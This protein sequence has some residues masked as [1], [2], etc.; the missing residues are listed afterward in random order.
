[1]KCTLFHTDEKIKKIRT[2]EFPLVFFVYD[3]V[4]DKGS[5]LFKKKKYREAIEYYIYAYSMLKWIEF[6][7]TKKGAEFLTVPSLDPILD[8]D[9][10]ECKCFLDDVAVEEDSYK[11][12]IVY[13]LMSLSSAYMELRHYS[14]A[15]DCLNECIA[16]AGDKVPDLFFR[17]SQARTFNKNSSDKEL[18][19]AKEDIEKAIS[20]KKEAIYVE[21]QEKLKKII[22]D[23]LKNKLELTESKMFFNLRIDIKS[24]SISQ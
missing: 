12:S 6:K 18:Q 9:I 8:A 4:K 10:K 2:K 17:R 19:I 21:H 3:E 13:L 24:K 14:E 15:I 7:D 22:E 20:L 5:K 11:A 1:M 16:V 23:K